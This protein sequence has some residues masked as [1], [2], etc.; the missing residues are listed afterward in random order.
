VLLLLY[1]HLSCS[2]VKLFAGNVGVLHCHPIYYAFFVYPCSRQLLRR[3]KIPVLPRVP[4]IPEN[5]WLWNFYWTCQNIGAFLFAFAV[6]LKMCLQLVHNTVLLQH[7]TIQ[8]ITLFTSCCV[9]LR[10]VSSNSKKIFNYFCPLS[11]LLHETATRSIGFF[12]PN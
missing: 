10:N 2:S 12:R 8:C 3:K 11:L 6:L 1:L 5:V 4:S 7:H 9:I